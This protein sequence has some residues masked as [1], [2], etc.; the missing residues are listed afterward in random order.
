[1]SVGSMS[2]AARALA[3]RAGVVARL[4]QR[5]TVHAMDIAMPGHAVIPAV[6]HPADRLAHAGAVAAI[7]VP[8]FRKFERD[9]IARMVDQDVG[10]DSQ[11]LRRSSVAPGRKRRDMRALARRG[12]DPRRRVF[13]GGQR[14][15][16][17]RHQTAMGE[18]VQKIATQNVTH[19]QIGI[20]VLRRLQQIAGFQPRAE[21]AE[22][23]I[24][25]VLH[26]LGVRRRQPHRSF[27]STSSEIYHQRRGRDRPPDH[28]HGRLSF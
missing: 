27:T 25:Q 8:V 22:D 20:R 14:L 26:R 17:P 9:Q 13:G 16:R 18:K 12:P 24:P 7:E 2:M 23:R 6:Q 28:F 21:I 10:Q 5:E 1:M 4:L 15:A 3:F 19:D 11:R